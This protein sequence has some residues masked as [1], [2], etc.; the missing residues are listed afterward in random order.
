M[1]VFLIDNSKTMQPFRE[2]VITTF[3]NLAHILEKAD[4]DGVDVFCTS[5]MDKKENNRRTENLTNFVRN[6]FCKGAGGRC[7]I[8]RSLTT[9]IGKVI[10]ELPPEAGS[11]LRRARSF[12]GILGKRYTGRPISIYI[13]TNGVWDSSPAAEKGLC[14]ADIP[15]RQLIEELKRRNLPRNQV[16]L[17]FLRFG[18]DETGIRRLRTLDDDIKRDL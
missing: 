4:E 7:F 17:Q 10:Q 5:Q 6:S 3:T 15:I 2:Q 9:L 11:G 8:E 13:L 18:N 14:N 1:Q 16:A 12:R